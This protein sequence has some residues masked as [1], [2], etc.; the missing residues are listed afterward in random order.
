[1]VHGFQ[2]TVVQLGRTLLLALK[3]LQFMKCV[4]TGVLSTKETDV[5][6]KSTL[7]HLV[8]V[9]GEQPNISARTITPAH[10]VVNSKPNCAPIRIRPV[11]TQLWLSNWPKVVKLRFRCI[12]SQ[13]VWYGLK[14]R[15]CLTAH[16]KSASMVPIYQLVLTS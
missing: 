12:P 10:Q 3:V 14:P 6:E 7:V 4:K 11:T 2:K 5:Q 16:K 1:M 9:S 15:K 8:V 13:V